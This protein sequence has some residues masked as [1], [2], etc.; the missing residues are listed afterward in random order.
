MKINQETIGYTDLGLCAYLAMHFSVL[1][2]RK[3][4]ENKLEFV[5]A[6]SPTLLKLTDDYFNNAA[7]VSPSG[8]FSSLKNL[9]SRIYLKI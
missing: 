2:L 5:F 7:V 9:K 4:S 8:Y 6:N 3:V 1:E